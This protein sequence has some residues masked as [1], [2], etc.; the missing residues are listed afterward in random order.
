MP[1]FGLIYLAGHALPLMVSSNL[2]I[3]C[4]YP[5]QGLR[6]MNF[7]IIITYHGP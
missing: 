5:H 6:A 4:Y 3:F 1:T 2:D 7:F